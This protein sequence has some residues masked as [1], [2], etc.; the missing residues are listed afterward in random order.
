MSASNSST[1]S[2]SNTITIKQS[3]TYSGIDFECDIKEIVVKRGERFGLVQ[4][5]PYYERL[6]FCATQGEDIPVKTAFNPA[7][8]TI[9]DMEKKAKARKNPNVKWQCPY[10]NIIISQKRYICVRH[11][12]KRQDGH[13]SICSARLAEE[14]NEE[15]DATKEPIK[16]IYE[17]EK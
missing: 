1:A 14:P 11:M 4:C 16:V 12:N 5:E 2:S 7:Y 3:V 8:R 6:Q 9:M 17:F 15:E 13:G 10:C